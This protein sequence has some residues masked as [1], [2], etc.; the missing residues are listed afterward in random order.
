MRSKNIFL[1]RVI[2]TDKKGRPMLSA[3]ESVIANWNVI[4]GTST[5]LFQNFD[6]KN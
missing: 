5:T 4:S 1:A 6:S 3:R 2:D